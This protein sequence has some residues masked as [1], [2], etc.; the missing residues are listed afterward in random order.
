MRLLNAQT[1]QLEPFTGPIPSGL[2]YAIL[3]HTWVTDEVTF[4]DMKD[5]ST[6]R[7]KKG[8][9]KIE[10]ASRMA[11]NHSVQYLWVDTC[12]I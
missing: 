10:A 2:P 3:S 6:A 9:A 8:F 7:T 5:L 12:C 1:F 11:I 4:E